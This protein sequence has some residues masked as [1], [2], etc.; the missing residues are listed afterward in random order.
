MGF[1]CFSSGHFAG[2]ESTML[3]GVVRISVG[4]LEVGSL[5]FKKFIV[6]L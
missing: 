5:S 6:N 3:Q 2:S 4:R 1:F